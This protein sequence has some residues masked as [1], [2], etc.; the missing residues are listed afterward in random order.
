MAAACVLN[1]FDLTDAAN[2]ELSFRELLRLTHKRAAT[3]RQLAVSPHYTGPGDAAFE[4]PPAPASPSACLCDD[5]AGRMLCG[6]GIQR[7]DPGHCGRCAD[8][9]AAGLS[10]K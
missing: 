10:R 1:P 5:C 4:L 6:V 9:P 8:P 3:G 7:P 2:T